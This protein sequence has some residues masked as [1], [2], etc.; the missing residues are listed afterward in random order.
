[1][2]YLQCCKYF[3]TEKVSEIF[4]K[5]VTGKSRRIRVSLV[6]F[7]SEFS[8]LLWIGLLDHLRD[9][10]VPTLLSLTQMYFFCLCDVI[11]I[12]DASALCTKL[13]NFLP[14]EK[15]NRKLVDFNKED[16]LQEVYFVGGLEYAEESSSSSPTK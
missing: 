4:K 7:R 9:C 12:F 1:M 15:S 16:L 11:V 10:E 8:H 6:Q 5:W 3:G 2:L 13:D 14:N